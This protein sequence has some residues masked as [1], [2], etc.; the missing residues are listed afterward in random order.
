MNTFNE[1]SILKNHVRKDMNILHG[2]GERG[3]PTLGVEMF[4]G[5]NLQHIC[6]F[7]LSPI[8]VSLG[9]FKWQK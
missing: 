4:E 5:L 2:L 9:G 3:F 8:L 6:F 7:F 1:K